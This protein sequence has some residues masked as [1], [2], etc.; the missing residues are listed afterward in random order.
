MTLP[1]LLVSVDRQ[2]YLINWGT[3]EDRRNI[4]LHG[5]GSADNRTGFVFGM[6][7]DY[8][9][10]LDP[11]EVEVEALDLGD[12]ELEYPFRRHARLWLKQDWNDSYYFGRRVTRKA[13]RLGISVADVHAAEAT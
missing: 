1:N 8:D 4:R 6:H 13:N 2:D 9:S 12:Y 11:G 10:R 3:S 5:V 7:L